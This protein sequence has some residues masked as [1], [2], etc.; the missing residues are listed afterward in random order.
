MCSRH[1][2]VE[3]IPSP[4]YHVQESATVSVPAVVSKSAPVPTMPQHVVLEGITFDTYERLLEDLGERQIRLTY[5]RGTLEIMT[6]SSRHE[7]FKRWVGRMVE[8]MTLELDI[9]IRSGGS[10]T[11]KRRDLEKGLEPDECYWIQN[12]PRVRGRIDLDLAK[13]PPPD[14]AIEV[15]VH[16]RSVNR[17]VIYAALGVSEVWRIQDGVI[18][19]HLRQQDARYK[20]GEASRC[21][22]WLPPQDLNAWFA[23]AG[24]QDETSFLREFQQWVRENLRP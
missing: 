6:L 9:P 11:W 4:N 1:G 17:M 7:S 18:Q 12:E 21:F 15:D 23:R 8:T 19:V 22:P 3:V 14:L 10:M 13:D 2:W 20:V 5:D 24:Q 16:S